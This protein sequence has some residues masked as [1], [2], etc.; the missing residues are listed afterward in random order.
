MV[1]ACEET[2]ECYYGD[3]DAWMDGSYA[4]RSQMV[5]NDD[6]EVEVWM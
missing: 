6:E 5:V 4:R 3:E 2:E 1:A